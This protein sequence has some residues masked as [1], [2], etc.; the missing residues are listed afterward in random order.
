MRNTSLQLINMQHLPQFVGDIFFLHLL[1][2]SGKSE[3]LHWG[4]LS[5]WGL[6]KT[7]AALAA[8]ATATATATK[9]FGLVQQQ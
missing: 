1:L 2:H 7:A 8:A 4:S 5:V 6:S 3:A 9:V